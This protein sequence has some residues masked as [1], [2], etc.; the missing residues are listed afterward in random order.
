MST[1]VDSATRGDAVGRIAGAESSAWTH[2][3]AG[4]RDITPMVLGIVPFGLALGAVIGSS[5]V[6]TGA[7]LASAP[8]ILAGAA[9]LVTLEMLEAGSNPVVIVASALLVNLRLVLY[10]ASLAPWFRGARLRH[11]L[12]LSAAVIDQTHFVAVP[13]FERGDLDRRRRVAYYA[14]ASS[15]IVVAWLGSQ[16]VAALV[17][18]ELP[19]SARLDMAAPLA[20]IGLL[21]KSVATRPSALAAVVGVGVASLGAG[22][23][24]H[25]TTLVATSAGITAAVFADRR[26]Q[27]RRAVPS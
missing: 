3:R 4:A 13:R 22:L 8:L 7:A 10:S 23:P 16:S 21:A 2:A 14:G 5:S 6:D 11:R 26:V 20:L 12:L 15:W 1:S 17:G 27:R 25:S 18:A 24:V 9:Q 19:E